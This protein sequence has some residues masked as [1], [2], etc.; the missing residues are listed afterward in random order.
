MAIQKFEDGKKVYFLKY[1]TRSGEQARVTIKA[2]GDLWLGQ[3]Y[4]EKKAKQAATTSMKHHE[5]SEIFQVELYATDLEYS[6]G[7]ADVG[8]PCRVWR[9]YEEDRKKCI[10]AG[11]LV[12]RKLRADFFTYKDGD[13]VPITRGKKRNFVTFSDWINA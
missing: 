6:M 3:F 1:L 10:D 9:E 5:D 7:M 12:A 8:D 2:G 13:S 4:D 11:F